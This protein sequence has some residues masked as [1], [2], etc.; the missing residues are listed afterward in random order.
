[1]LGR[2]GR[3]ADQIGVHVRSA[4]RVDRLLGVADEHERRT[5]VLPH[6]REDFILDR[7]GVLELVDECRRIAGAH[8]LGEL[9]AAVAVERGMDA[10]QQII[11]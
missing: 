5:G 10:L 7:V 4:K 9:G 6:A 8:A 11:E 2:R 1:M 3:F